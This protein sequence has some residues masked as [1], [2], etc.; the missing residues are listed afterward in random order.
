MASFPLRAPLVRHEPG[1]RMAATPS[2]R[3]TVANEGH[4][5]SVK[6]DLVHD[7][8]DSPYARHHSSTTRCRWLSVY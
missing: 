6:P 7:N 3:T 5:V 1:M 8:L 2:G 4:L